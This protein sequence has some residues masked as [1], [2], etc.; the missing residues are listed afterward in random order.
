[1][2]VGF[3]I[4]TKRGAFMTISISRFQSTSA[5]SEGSSG[6][7]FN[8]SDKDDDDGLDTGPPPP[9]SDHQ[10]SLSRHDNAASRVETGMRRLDLLASDT[11][12]NAF[13]TRLAGTTA[14]NVA[15]LRRQM[16]SAYNFGKVMG[17]H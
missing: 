10:Y 7:M 3:R 6:R 5:S 11:A 8:R 14:Q 17:G 15:D 4:D 16:R 9:L 1:M 2:E 13:A 12:A